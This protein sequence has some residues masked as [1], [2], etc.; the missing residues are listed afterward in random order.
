L[1]DELKLQRLFVSKKRMKTGT[2]P[3]I[4]ESELIRSLAASQLKLISPTENFVTLVNDDNGRK[5][6]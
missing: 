3:T 4:M 6:I 1:K 5:G 2:I